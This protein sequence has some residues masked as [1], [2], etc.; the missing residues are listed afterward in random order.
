MVSSISIALTGLDAASKRLNASASNIANLQ[1]TGSLEEGGQKPYAPVT[2]QHTAITDTQGGVQGVST[3]MVQRSDPFVAAF[4]PDSP[5]ADA[6]GLIGVPDIDLSEEAVHML[7][8]ET[9]FKASLAA[10]RTSDEMS[11]ELFRLF[12][13][14]V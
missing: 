13:K 14:K 6:N 7:L 11:S 1:T 3:K 5:H 12:D 8:A 2:T 10:L 4:D 9:Q